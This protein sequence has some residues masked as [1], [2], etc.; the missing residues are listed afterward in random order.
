MIKVLFIAD[1]ANCPR[2]WKMANTLTRAGY[3]VTVIEWDRRSEFPR[4]ETLGKIQVFRMRI[5]SPY[6][7]LSSF[8]FPIWAFFVAFFIITNRYDIV[9]PQNFNNLVFSYVVCKLKKVKI[10]YD[11]ADTYADAY[12]S[13]FPC[14]LR[15]LVNYLEQS[16]MQQTDYTIMADAS[17]IKQLKM[18]PPKCLVINNSPPDLVTTVPSS[19]DKF[20]IFYAGII[21][22]DRGL[23]HLI[24]AV[25]D[26]SDVELIIAGFGSHEKWLVKALQRINNV[27]FLGRI[28]YTSVLSYTCKADCI[29]ALYDPKKTINIFASPN[30]LFEAMMAGKPIIVSEG[31][32]MAELVRKWNCGLI[33]RYGDVKA[34]K[35]AILSLKLDRN[36]SLN[37]GRN[38]RKAYETE[39]SW[40]IMASRLLKIYA[41]LL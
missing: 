24:H 9:Q 23:D 31:S 8:F 20:I 17:R 21:S 10:V 32:S 25:R 6:G 15:R 40:S 2:V 38:G 39:Y 12:L 18:V 28:S 27:I 29:V 19:E 5:H 26:F 35:N 7:Y 14:H 22:E 4:S 13:T 33:V 30:K 1:F 34:I 16:L 41:E 3:C 37:L 11:V 36:L